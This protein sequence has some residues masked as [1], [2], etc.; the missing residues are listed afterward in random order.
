LHPYITRMADPE[1]PNDDLQSLHEKQVALASA[2]QKAGIGFLGTLFAG[3]FYKPLRKAF[4]EGEATYAA[5]AQQLTKTADQLKTGAINS[6]E[7]AVAA[8]LAWQAIVKESATK[9]CTQGGITQEKLIK[10]IKKANPN[11]A[12]PGDKTMER[13]ISKLEQNNEITRRPK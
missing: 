9:I 4:V 1:A 12:L 7:N 13:F 3:S 2:L 8:K 5:T 11:K 10:E 6:R